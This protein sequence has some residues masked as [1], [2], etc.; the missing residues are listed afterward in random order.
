MST[1]MSYGTSFSGISGK[2]FSSPAT[3]TVG[4]NGVKGLNFHGYIHYN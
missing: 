3:S 2:N 4:P 1:G